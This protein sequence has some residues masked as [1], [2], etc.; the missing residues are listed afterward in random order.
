MQYITAQHSTARYSAVPYGTARY[1]TG[2]LDV[3]DMVRN[4]RRFTEIQQILP[5]SGDSLVFG[6]LGG[7]EILDV[8]LGSGDYILSQLGL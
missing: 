5:N 4:G 1:S 6:D 3:S 7:F 8:C 2:S